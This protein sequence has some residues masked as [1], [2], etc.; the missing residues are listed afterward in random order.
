MP[1]ESCRVHPNIYNS[2]IAK[3]CRNTLFM[4]NECDVPIFLE[5]KFMRSRYSRKMF[6]QYIHSTQNHIILDCETVSDE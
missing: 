2:G 3:Q 5:P 6:A 4:K 1:N